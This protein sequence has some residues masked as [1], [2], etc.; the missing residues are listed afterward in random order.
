MMKH[1][2]KMEVFWEDALLIHIDR[3]AQTRKPDQPMPE[4]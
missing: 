1:M 3:V 2:S 4:M